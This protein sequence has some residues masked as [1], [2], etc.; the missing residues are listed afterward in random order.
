MSKIEFADKTATYS[1][2]AHALSIA[3]NSKLPLDVVVS[4]QIKQLKDGTGASVTDTYKAGNTA[5]N[6]GVYLVKVSFGVNGKNAENYTTAPLEKEAYL[7][8]LRASYDEEMK[9]VYLDTQWF[10]FEEG[11]TYEILL[12]CE[13]PEGVTPQFTLTNARGETID[14]KMEKVTSSVEGDKTA[15]KTA[16]KYLFT[17]ETAGEYTCVVTFVHDNEN[18]DMIKIDL[19][20][21]FYIS[22][23][24]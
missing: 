1:G 24:V 16:Y 23:V 10:E 14:G 15:V 5:I 21:M 11:K 8:I 4:Y 2:E 7:T 22:S 9:D 20:A 19:N 13:L 6:A 17:I 18:Y 12:D 3:E